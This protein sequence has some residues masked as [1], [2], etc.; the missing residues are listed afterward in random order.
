MKSWQSISPS[1]IY[2]RSPSLTLLIDW[3]SATLI[4]RFADDSIVVSHRF[5]LSRFVFCPCLTFLLCPLLVS[6]DSAI[7]RVTLSHCLRLQMYRNC[8][9]F[10]ESKIYC[11]NRITSINCMY[12]KGL[13]CLMKLKGKRN[14]SRNDERSERDQD[15]QRLAQLQCL[16]TQ[17]LVD[18]RQSSMQ[19]QRSMACTETRRRP[20]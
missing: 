3:P 1:P 15:T 19:I 16:S 12:L 6:S 10:L 8:G 7:R 14:W 4:E 13:H 5:M 20:A 18:K 2:H 17:M 11:S 9:C